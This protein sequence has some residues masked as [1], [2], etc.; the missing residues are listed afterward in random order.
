MPAIERHHAAV[1][2]LRRAIGADALTNT[3]ARGLLC[4][5]LPMLQR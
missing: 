2:Q 1:L 3:A 4:G 5:V